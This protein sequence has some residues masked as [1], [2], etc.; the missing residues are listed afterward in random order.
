MRR[1]GRMRGDEGRARS[2]DWPRL[3]GVRRRRCPELRKTLSEHVF[4]WTRKP[5]DLR[6]DILCALKLRWARHSG[7]IVD[8]L[9][10]FTTARHGRRL[11]WKLGSESACGLYVAGQVVLNNLL[12]D[13]IHRP[14]LCSHRLY[15]SQSCKLDTAIE[16][17]HTIIKSANCLYHPGRWVT[18]CR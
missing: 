3:A 4:C 7:R 1:L 17:D 8:R 12:F 15:T 14:L 2:C 13:P 5:F 9:M 16:M 18:V 6:L 10:I 11:V